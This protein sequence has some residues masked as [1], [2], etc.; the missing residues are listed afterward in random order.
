[1][2]STDQDSNEYNNDG[3]CRNGDRRNGDRRKSDEG[4]ICR[5]EA[6]LDFLIEDFNNYRKIEELEANIRKSLL[7]EIHNKQLKT[8]G[9]FAGLAFSVTIL[10]SVI[11]FIINKFFTVN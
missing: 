11:G 6:R 3:D 4:R 2:T 5:I 10:A 7:E 1:M 9:F 8:S